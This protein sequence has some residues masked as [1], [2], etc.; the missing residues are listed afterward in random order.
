MSIINLN[1]YQYNELEK[2]CWGS[3]SPV[4]YFMS[5]GDLISVINNFHL[6]N[7]KFFPLPIFLDID[8]DTKRKLENKN[9]ADLIF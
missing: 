2:L 1:Y 5:S 9:K 4:N 7:G 3:F 8:E 6:R